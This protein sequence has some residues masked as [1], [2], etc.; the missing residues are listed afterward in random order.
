M[1][2]LELLKKDW[3]TSKQNNTNICAPQT[4]NEKPIKNILN[5]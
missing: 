4:K 3:D 5:C 1:D 2:E